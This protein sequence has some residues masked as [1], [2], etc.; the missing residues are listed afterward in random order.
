MN[1][2]APLIRTFLAAYPPA[3]I[4]AG[5]SGV[6]APFRERTRAVRWAPDTQLHFTLRFFGDLDLPARRAI[7]GVLDDAAEDLAPVSFPIRGLGAFPNWRRPR[8]IWA[9]AG[10]GGEDLEAAARRLDIRFNEAGLGRADKPFKAHLTVGRIRDGQRLDA[11]LQK[12][13]ERCPLATPVFMIDTL[14]LMASRLGPGGA[15]HSELYA[16]PLGGGG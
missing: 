8:V 12:D 13:L 16:I 11:E 1:E 3:D 4:L 14:R 15:D 2:P 6:L 10:P 9:G 5:V 7:I